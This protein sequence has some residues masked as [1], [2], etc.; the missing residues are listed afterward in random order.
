[1]DATDR[2]I[3]HAEVLAETPAGLEKQGL[4]APGFKFLLF[5]V[6]RLCAMKCPICWT[7]QAHTQIRHKARPER[8]DWLDD[9]TLHSLLARF[10]ELGGEVVAT[11]SEGEPLLGI[12]YGFMKRVARATRNL[13]FG[14]H[15][16]TI[17]KDLTEES[18]RELASLNPRIS[19]TISV[20]AG[21]AE[22]YDRALGRHEGKNLGE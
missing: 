4:A 3:A 2:G 8:I 17:G 7:A 15:V 9:S 10:K 16:F 19:F 5:N 6:S 14:M 13:G 22:V 11:M 1:M 18:L 21:S 12:N 20:N